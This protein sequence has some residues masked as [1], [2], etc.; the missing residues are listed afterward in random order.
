MLALHRGYI[1]TAQA[2]PLPAHRVLAQV[3]SLAS[4]I[5]CG[6]IHAA[7]TQSACMEDGLHCRPAHELTS[8]QD[9]HI[10]STDR[11]GQT[12]YKEKLCLLT[13]QVC[14]PMTWPWGEMAGLTTGCRVMGSMKPGRG[15]SS[16][17]HSPASAS[18]SYRFLYRACLL[19]PAHL[20]HAAPIMLYNTPNSPLSGGAQEIS[21]VRV[22]AGMYTAGCLTSH[23]VM[24]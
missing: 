9:C 17:T 21:H 23:G 18:A 4:R 22:P 20:H 14:S 3:T 8:A 2:T 6:R 5:V 7:L 12:K 1:R 13:F 11:N 10:D 15:L 19:R 24:A 16:S